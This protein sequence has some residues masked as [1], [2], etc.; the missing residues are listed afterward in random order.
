MA[1]APVGSPKP[2]DDPFSI[3][4]SNYLQ[5]PLVPPAKLPKVAFPNYLKFP[6]VPP[7]KLPTELALGPTFYTFNVLSPRICFCFANPYCLAG[8]AAFIEILLL[9]VSKHVLKRC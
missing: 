5:F 7:A 3:A 1:C 8:I 9:A 2:P 4:F 6:W